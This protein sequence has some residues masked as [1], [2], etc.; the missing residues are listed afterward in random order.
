MAGRCF[1][2]IDERDKE[3]SFATATEALLLWSIHAA[4]KGSEGLEFGH[5]KRPRLS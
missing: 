1:R 4:G 3:E 2:Y 5:E